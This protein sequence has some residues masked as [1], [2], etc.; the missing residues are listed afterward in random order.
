MG[1]RAR[2]HTVHRLSNR[3]QKHRTHTRPGPFATSWTLNVGRGDVVVVVVVVGLLII[4][5]RDI[6]TGVQLAPPVLSTRKPCVQRLHARKVSL[7]REY[8]ASDQQ[9]G[10][11]RSSSHGGGRLTRASPRLKPYS[12]VFPFHGV[13]RPLRFATFLLTP[14][15]ESLTTR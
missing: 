5:L 10:L 14:F 4:E 13:G 9:A 6:C 15:H 11:A 2:D 3:G 12:S 7:V 1:V 8:Y